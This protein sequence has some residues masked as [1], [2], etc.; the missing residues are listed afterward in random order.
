[1]FCERRSAGSCSDPHVFISLSSLD[2]LY[3]QTLTR[4]VIR[5]GAA[6]DH[7]VC[8]LPALMHIAFDTGHRHRAALNNPDVD[9]DLAVVSR[10]Y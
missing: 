4:D 5:I 7:D 2:S 1:M 3:K 10:G 8:S 9:L 6:L